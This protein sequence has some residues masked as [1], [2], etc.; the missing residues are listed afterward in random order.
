MNSLLKIGAAMLVILAVLSANAPTRRSAIIGEWNPLSS[1]LRLLG[2]EAA[3]CSGCCGGP[4]PRA[5]L[6]RPPLE[7]P[8]CA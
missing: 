2:D 1:L 3:D 7:L 4:A 5:A 6:D 8:G